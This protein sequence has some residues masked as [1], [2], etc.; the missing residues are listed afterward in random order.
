MWKLEKSLKESE[1]SIFLTIK[2]SFNEKIKN[3]IYFMMSKDK[4]DLIKVAEIIQN[5]KN[6]S[7]TYNRFIKSDIFCSICKK[8]GH[9][10]ENCFFRNKIDKIQDKEKLNL[11][12][13]KT[14]KSP[15]SI[16]MIE[17]E[18]YYCLL[19]TGCDINI[20]SQKTLKKLSQIDIYKSDKEGYS[21][22]GKRIKTLGKTKITFLYD[23]KQ[24][25]EWFYII[26]TDDEYN[27]L[28][29]LGYEW[30]SKN[31]IDLYYFSLKNN[32]EL[33]NSDIFFR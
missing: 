18:K 4:Q 15:Q 14:N 17:E 28:V 9:K 8:N 31:K 32:F 2:D 12:N 19:D 16:I 20:I 5:R 21:I 22:E 33:L 3:E 11:K 24:F 10:N 13:F 27:D 7:N 1:E 26:E 6:I 29:I 30:L 23:E 25:D